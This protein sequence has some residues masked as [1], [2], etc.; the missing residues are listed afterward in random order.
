MPCKS[1]HIDANSIISFFFTTEQYSTV[2]IY[3]IFYPF[4][5]RWTLRLLLVLAILEH[6]SS[7]IHTPSWDWDNKECIISETSWPI[8]DKSKLWN[9]ISKKSQ[10][11]D[12]KWEHEYS[13]IQ[14][15]ENSRA[16]MFWTSAPRSGHRAVWAPGILKMWMKQT[17]SVKKQPKLD[18]DVQK[19]KHTTTIQPQ[20]VAC[21]DKHS[22]AEQLGSRS[23][24]ITRFQS[25]AGWPWATCLTSL[26][27]TAS[28]VEWK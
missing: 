5:S 26:C 2:Y 4:F 28:S 11:S 12:F 21:N 18:K 23:W 14:S 17:I 3:H 25:L 27:F 22:P 16:N 7:L 10:K 20:V 6:S 8:F 24:R 19:C 13:T 1:I 9:H 15:L